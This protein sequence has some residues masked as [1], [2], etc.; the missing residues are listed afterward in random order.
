MIDHQRTIDNIRTILASAGPTSMEGIWAVAVEYADAC[1]MVNERLRKCD[2]LLREGLRSEAIHQC[3]M[4]PNLLRLVATLDFPEVPTW[5]AYLQSNGLAPPSPLL[6]EVAAELNEAYGQEQPLTATLRRHRLLALSRSPLRERISTLRKLAR[7]DANNPVW[8]EDLRIYEQARQQEIRRST[9][10]ASRQGN[11]AGLAELARDVQSGVWLEPLPT[12]L[13]QQVCDAHNRLLQQQSRSELGHIEPQLNEAFSQ[14][15]VTRGRMLRERWNA[16]ATVVGLEE[17]DILYERAAPALEW[18]D[19]QDRESAD[20]TGYKAAVAA[21]ELALDDEEG[22][23]ILERLAHAVLRYERPI[24][25]VLEQRLRTRM[26]GLELAKTRRLRLIVAAA[27][28]F[29]VL[30]AA[31]VG[32]ARVSRQHADQVATHVATLQILMD[33]RHFEE[34]RKHLDQLTQSAPNIASDVQIQE[35]GVQ[36]AS[37]ISDEQV[38]RE[39]FTSA[40]SAAEQ[41]GDTHA[42][43]ESL[44]EAR[45][46]AVLDSEK[47]R[48]LKLE[49]A[50]AATDRRRQTERDDQFVKD[51]KGLRG[52]IDAIG[53][54][55][56][57][58]KAL[59]E[60]RKD[61]AALIGKSTEISPAIMEQGTAAQARIQ[62]LYKTIERQQSMDST[63]LAIDR[64]VG[65][66]EVFR[67]S[68]EL[69]IKDFPESTQAVDFKR[70]VG[71][72]P[73]W[74]TIDAWNRFIAE[75]QKQDVAR[76]DAARAKELLAASNDIL[77]DHGGHPAAAELRLRI[78][79]LESIIRRQD[80]S[81][82][83]L[84]A[85]LNEL[86]SD[87]L[88]ASLWMVEAVD[89]KER[90]FTYY[91]IA[92]LPES[93]ANQSSVQ[94][95]HIADFSRNASEKLRVPLKSIKYTGSAPQS[96]IARTAMD[97]LA[98]IN[99][100]LWEQTF[101]KIIRAINANERLDPILKVMLLQKVLDVACPGSE[102]LKSAFTKFREVLAS[103]PI[104][105]AVPWMNT[106]NEDARRARALATDLLKRLPPL[107]QATE[108]AAM[109]LK[110]FK[111]T[112]GESYKWVG[113]L[114][115]DADGGWQCR[116]AEQT[117]PN[118][119]LFVA[120]PVA[121]AKA[122]T[123]S[124]I[125]KVNA[126]KVELDRTE[127]AAF[128]QG[129]PVF[130]IE[131]SP[132]PMAAARN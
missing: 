40:I 55:H 78:P 114:A 88:I 6:V 90:P 119:K 27:G 67:S 7:L 54:N 76:I 30:I 106:K 127:P 77:R 122:L 3:E 120:R 72:A 125:G 83:K 105:P 70:V 66:G 39:K 32:Y 75:W 107:R 28:V 8:N 96:V 16:L 13:V 18:L 52:R 33:Q 51:L 22:L 95:A 84:Y 115:H 71:E 100:Q 46:L 112:P 17:T 29:V 128:V 130:A 12:A 102:S 81:G 44:R 21:L 61:L 94:V 35:L 131:K 117:P 37:L 43:R 38:R 45:R 99:E 48:V 31:G 47:A 9:D 14:F 15:D 25:A 62:G 60:V 68:L 34:A 97:E 116:L 56:P 11:L 53:R 58:A 113:W 129:R 82:V 108:A 98:R 49:T 93:L 92:P 63:M 121:A 4:E 19:Q 50:I 2:Q 85:P 42:D 65:D 23:T 91:L 124:T 20:E 132:T 104:D 80:E 103:V 1:E 5:T 101:I 79:Q 59:A 69:L 24:P 41:A 73:L 110:T 109:S 111:V 86:F 126:G 57:D 118:C 87:P 10:Q 36:L 123:W 74:K 64:A 26:A 89:E